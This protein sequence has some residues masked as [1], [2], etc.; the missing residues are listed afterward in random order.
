MYKNL[1]DLKVEVESEIYNML[2]EVVNLRPE[3]IV[4]SLKGKI[5]S[6]YTAQ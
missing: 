5:T 2:T 6:W 1:H 3:L 4:D